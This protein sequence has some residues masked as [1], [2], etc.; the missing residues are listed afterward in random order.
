MTTAGSTAGG[1]RRARRLSG[2]TVADGPAATQDV[3]AS[4]S[5]THGVFVAYSRS[6]AASITP[7][8]LGSVTQTIL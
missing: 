8:S 3:P 4:A 2:G 7:Q 5:H 6:P 1:A